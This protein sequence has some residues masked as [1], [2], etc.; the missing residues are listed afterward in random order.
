VSGMVHGTTLVSGII[1]HRHKYL[2]RLFGMLAK[3][4]LTGHD[5]HAKGKLKMGKMSKN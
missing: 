1:S 3:K 4:S 2:D 5:T